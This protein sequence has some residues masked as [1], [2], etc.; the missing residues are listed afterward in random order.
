MM[1]AWLL[2]V[3]LALGACARLPVQLAGSFPSITVAE[4]Q[5]QDLEGERVRWGGEIVSAEPGKDETCFEVV[6]QPLGRTARPRQTDV[7][8]GRFLACAPGF[9]DP[10]IYAPKREVTVVGTLMASTTGKVGEYAY[11]FPQVEAQAVHLWPERPPEQA[12]YYSP[13]FWGYPS[14]GGGYYRYPRRH[15][16]RR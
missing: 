2:V 5:A 7:P 15:G 11:R 1:R 9:Y 8:H 13:G 6:S 12:L 4:A 14:W 16:R 10:A 3:P